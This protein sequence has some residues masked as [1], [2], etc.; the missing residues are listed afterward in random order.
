MNNLSSNNDFLIVGYNKK[1]LKDIVNLLVNTVHNINKKDYTQNQLNAWVNPNIAFKAW[2]HRFKK[3]KPDI[4][5]S[6]D[7]VLGFCEFDKGY[8]D[9]FYVH[10]QHQGCGVGKLLLNQI[11]AIAENNKIDTIKVDAS[12]TAKTFFEKFGFKQVT[13]NLVKIENQELVNFSLEYL[14]RND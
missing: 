2:Q 10:Y 9:C 3:S 13:E 11:F 14:R 1:Y 8:I 6:G 5:I 12:I 4:C 7:K